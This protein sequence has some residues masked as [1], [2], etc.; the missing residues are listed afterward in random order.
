MD[1][2]EMTPDK[3]WKSALPKH[4]MFMEGSGM[5]VSPK[6]SEEFCRAVV[7][8]ALECSSDKEAWFRIGFAAAVDAIARGTLRFRPIYGPDAAVKLAWRDVHNATSRP[9][10][11]TDV[12]G[13]ALL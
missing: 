11:V 10:V 1:A 5:P 7:S 9:N 3:E 8:D 12:M 2:N 13:T 4:R 6:T